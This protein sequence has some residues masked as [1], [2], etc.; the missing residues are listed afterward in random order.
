[1][2]KKRK[3]NSEL[4]NKYW[5]YFETY[6]KTGGYLCIITSIGKITCEK[7]VNMYKIARI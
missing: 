4:C 7:S 2:L 3:K 5:K 1:M 6:K